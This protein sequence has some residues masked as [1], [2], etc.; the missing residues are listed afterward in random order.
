MVRQLIVRGVTM[1]PKDPR[2]DQIHDT[3]ASI[4]VY[5]IDSERDMKI[6]KALS[7]YNLNYRFDERG[8]RDYRFSTLMSRD[9]DPRF[10][11]QTVDLRQN[12]GTIL[13]QGTL[14]SSVSN[15]VAYQLRHILIKENPASTANASI[16]F[17]R[18]YIYYNGRRESGYSTTQDTGLSIKQGLQAVQRDGSVP[19]QMWPYIIREFSK[20]PLEEIFSIGQQNKGINYY[21]IAPDLLHLKKCLKDGYVVSFG[22]AIFESFMTAEV[23][24]TGNVPVPQTNEERVGGHA[25]T[26]VGYDDTRQVFIVANSWGADWGDNGFCYIPYTVVTNPTTTGDFWTV[27]AFTYKN[28][29]SNQQSQLDSR[30][31]Y[32]SIPPPSPIPVPASW[33][34]QVSY[35]KDDIVM[36]DGFQWKCLVAHTSIPQ[37]SP[38]VVPA[39]WEEIR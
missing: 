7:Q 22:I 30:L 37:W 16:N 36:Y 32:Q 8:H 13:D 19:E 3:D 20:R 26:L 35:E 24:Q 34:S 4:Q 2:L 10:L 15:S 14:G 12:W 17:S 1:A 38:P 39:V 21:D 33:R 5:H 31:W 18:L 23:A 6:N 27:R 25:M 9:V 29:Q 28:S 11:P